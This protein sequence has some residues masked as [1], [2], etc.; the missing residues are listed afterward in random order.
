MIDTKDILKKVHQDGKKI[1]SKGTETFEKAYKAT[2]DI[3]GQAKK[4]GPELLTTLVRKGEK[5]WEEARK[6]IENLFAG[7][8]QK[9]KNVHKDLRKALDD[10][11]KKVIA[12]LPIDLSGLRDLLKTIEEKVSK[13]DFPYVHQNHTPTS[14]PIN[15]YEQLN[16]RKILPLLEKLNKDQLRTILAFEEKHQNRVTITRAIK[17]LLT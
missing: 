1:A 4:D 8:K 6:I 13:L 9:L 10:F 3:I 7:N 16:V 14:L 2:R 12:G 17:K 5:E 15:N 11:R